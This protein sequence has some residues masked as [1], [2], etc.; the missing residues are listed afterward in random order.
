MAEAWLGPHSRQAAVVVQ[1]G[2]IAVAAV[3]RVGAEVVAA[4]ARLRAEV[5]VREP[6]T[7]V[8]ARARAL[9]SEDVNP[10]A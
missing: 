2:A 8:V 4:V 10:D 7:K 5:V 6:A 3:A 9:V 1:A